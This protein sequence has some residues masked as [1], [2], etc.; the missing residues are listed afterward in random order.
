[1]RRDQRP[2]HRVAPLHGPDAVAG[3]ADDQDRA[4]G[5]G[6]RPGGIRAGQRD[7]GGHPASP[8]R[9]AQQPPAARGPQRTARGGQV[10]PEAGEAL[11][12][13]PG[14]G[15]VRGHRQA[16]RV[17]PEQPLVRGGGNRYPQ[18]A[19]RGQRC[20]RGRRRAG[21][22][23]ASIAPDAWPARASSNRA[24]RRA[25]LVDL[26][27][28]VQ[29]ATGHGHLGIA[30]HAAEDAAGW[31]AR[32]HR[33]R[34]SR[35]RGSRGHAGRDV[36]GARA[37]AAREQQAQRAQRGEQDGRPGQDAVAGAFVTFMT[38]DGR[39]RP[40]L[41][42]S[43]SRGPP[44]ARSRRPGSPGRRRNWPAARARCTGRSSPGVACGAGGCH[45]ARRRS[46]S[47]SLTSR[48]S[49]RAG[50]SRRDPVAG[51]HQGQRAARGGLGR[52]VQHDRAVGGA[53]HPAVADPHHVA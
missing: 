11:I 14:D 8:R 24:I 46:S 34:G 26:P 6:A 48:V 43:A 7:H 53:R 23:V 4:V 44:R 12:R 10:V 28:H 15:D 9:H 19:T 13:T 30:E 16:D 3:L 50:T 37:A 17:H 36:P 22:R 5:T 40:R 18:P 35:C 52:D 31:T 38:Y 42:L 47:S 27:G 32:G 45:C 49:V 41:G 20:G 51:L 1:M 25:W 2:G 39:R 29:P 33:R 21:S